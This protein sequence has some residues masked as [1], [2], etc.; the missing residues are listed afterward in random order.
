MQNLL[1][2]HF[3][4]QRKA[5]EWRD[6]K[7]REG[8]IRAKSMFVKYREGWL[9][10]YSGVSTGQNQV[11]HNVNL[12]ISEW[13]AE[14]EVRS[15]KQWACFIRI[16]SRGNKVKTGTR[17]P[18]VVPFPGINQRTWQKAKVEEKN[19]Q[20]DQ[21]A[22]SKHTPMPNAKHNEEAAVALS[23]HLREEQNLLRQT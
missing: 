2:G 13:D 17:S 5:V 15:P 19:I 18:I 16:K 7:I 22:Q 12:I 4:G 6:R 20:R 21:R 10:G 9:L 1:R 23:T 3:S 11:Y 8:I 14:Y